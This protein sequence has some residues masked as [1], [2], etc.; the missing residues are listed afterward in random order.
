MSKP[1]E[2]SRKRSLIE[3]AYN[4][5]KIITYNANDVEIEY[6]ITDFSHNRKV[7]QLNHVNSP[8]SRSE[9][10]SHVLDR[11]NIADVIAYQQ[12]LTDY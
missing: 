12:T 4:S 11:T 2:P 7:V 6:L 5:S 3:H 1:T 8:A 9:S 10:Y